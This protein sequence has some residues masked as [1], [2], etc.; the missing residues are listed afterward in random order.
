MSP[1]LPIFGRM[2]HF[3]YAT[4]KYEYEHRGNEMGEARQVK[5]E[6]A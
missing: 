3:G 2:V 5:F 1:R 6:G 4:V